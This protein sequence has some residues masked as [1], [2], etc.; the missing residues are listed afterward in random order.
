MKN[1]MHGL[2]EKL[3]MCMSYFSPYSQKVKKKKKNGTISQT[4]KTI[5]IMNRMF[6]KKTLFWSL[7][8]SL[9]VPKT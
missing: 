4:Q 9:L 6:T 8:K 3:E 1:Q 7:K 5:D 2:H